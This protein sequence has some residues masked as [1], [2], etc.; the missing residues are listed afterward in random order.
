[1][2][3]ILFFIHAITR[4]VDYRI[5]NQILPTH[6]IPCFAILTSSNKVIELSD[7]INISETLEVFK[8]QISEFVNTSVLQIESFSMLNS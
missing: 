5:D 7:E 1:M 6:S 8:D 2:Y 4:V 3:S